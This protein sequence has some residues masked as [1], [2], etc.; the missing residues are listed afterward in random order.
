MAQVLTKAHAPYQFLCRPS[1]SSTKRT[2]LYGSRDAFLGNYHP[3]WA[4]LQKE[5]EC[6]GRYSS[7]F[8]DGRKQEQARK[9]LEGALGEKKTEFEKWNREIEKRQEKG[10]GGASGRGGWFGGGG[11]FGWFGEEHFWEEAQQAIL[12]IIGIVSLYLL[13]AKGNVMFA[14]I[15]N[16][17]L[18][19]LR[20]ARNWLTFI[21]SWF[22]GKAFAPV[23][24]SGPM[25]QMVSNTYQTEMSAKERVVRKWGMD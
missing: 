17:L 23:S 7:F 2:S 25:N 13:L 9:A 16:S 24:G 1:L 14:V 8:A 21:S 10:G 15:F 22:T 4:A 12:A 5:L 20:G 3:R 6:E 19:V 18:F 11:W